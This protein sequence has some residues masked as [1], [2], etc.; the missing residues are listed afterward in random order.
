MQFRDIRVYVAIPMSMAPPILEKM[1][2]AGWTRVWEAPQIYHT[3]TFN[4]AMEESEEVARQNDIQTMKGKVE[5]T[6]EIM[7][8]ARG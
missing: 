1:A 3:L 5:G 7:E 4:E 6:R 2:R 8:A